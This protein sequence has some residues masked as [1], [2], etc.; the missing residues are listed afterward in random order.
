MR[1]LELPEEA[2]T[3]QQVRGWSEGQVV[4]SQTQFPSGKRKEALKD[5]CLQNH[6]N[7]LDIAEFHTCPVLFCETSLSWYREYQDHE[8]GSIS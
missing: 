8:S 3:K 4:A 5:N 7:I 6:V 1:N 2:R